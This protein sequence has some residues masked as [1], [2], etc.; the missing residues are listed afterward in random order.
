METADLARR[1]QIYNARTYQQTR[2]EMDFNEIKCV[3]QHKTA[4]KELWFWTKTVDGSRIRKTRQ[5]QMS[6]RKSLIFKNV[7]EGELECSH[8]V[9]LLEDAKNVE[10]VLPIEV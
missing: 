1:S 7:N 6:R 2:L 5:K 8:T 4:H 9:A 3:W 10:N